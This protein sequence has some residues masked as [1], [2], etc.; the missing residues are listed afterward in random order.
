M[1]LTQLYQ[2]DNATNPPE[3]SN[4]QTEL[5]NSSSL[6]NLQDPD[7]LTGVIE[8]LINGIL[9]LTARREMVYAND[10][11]RRILGQLNQDRPQA[12]F[13][14]KEIWHICQSLIGSH[15]LFPNQHWRIESEIFT[16]DSTSLRIRAQWLNL[17]DRENSLILITV[18]D[19][20]QKIKN[21]AVDESQKYGLTPR[22]KEVWL[23]HR[24]N[25]TYKQIASELCITPNTVKKHMRSIH[26][27]QKELFE[28]E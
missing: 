4:P 14:P 18:E 16:D 19:R 21:L 5:P 9:I 24:A 26:A 28:A 1:I 2:V 3:N 23:L 27:K 13:I 6:P 15:N 11:A 20:Y 10:T 22:E 8:K 17:E 25:Y 12:D 7:I